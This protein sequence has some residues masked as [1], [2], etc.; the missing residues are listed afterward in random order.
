MVG[1]PEG[2]KGHGLLGL[3]CQVN[4]Q[5]LVRSAVPLT[6]LVLSTDEVLLRCS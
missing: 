3:Q 4:A 5:D 1:S 2:A 6:K